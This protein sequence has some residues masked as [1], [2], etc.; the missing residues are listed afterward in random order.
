MHSLFRL[1]S[2]GYAE[3][4][5]NGEKYPTSKVAMMMDSF[6]G[7]GQDDYA[8]G[9]QM[10]KHTFN[11]EDKLGYTPLLRAIEYGDFSVV[12][13]IVNELDTAENKG[14]YHSAIGQFRGSLD[15]QISIYRHVSDVGG[16]PFIN[17]LS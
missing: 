8:H 6:H 15:F 14:T 13:E 2:V 12:R 1:P 10:F 4:I 5:E 16:I 17:E 11:T 7:L 9:L 3:I